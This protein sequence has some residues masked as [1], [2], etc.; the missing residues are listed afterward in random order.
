MSDQ[1][2]PS[3]PAVDPT[4]L[5]SEIKATVARRLAA[6]EYP[7]ELLDRLEAGFAPLDPE[8]PLETRA[9][10]ETVRTLES[11][12]PGLGRAVVFG[13]RLI[14]RSVAWYVR[15][16]AE[17]QTRFNFG[18]VRHLYDLEARVARLEAERDRPGDALPADEPAPRPGPASG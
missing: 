18:L 10:L 13:K 11:R 6:G 5:V 9:R 4:A 7:R 17:D 14:R 8:P 12:R 1:T 2:G 16:I 15:P 3:P